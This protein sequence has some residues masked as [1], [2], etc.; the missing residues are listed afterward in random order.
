MFG[1]IFRYV[2]EK[3]LEQFKTSFGIVLK[4]FLAIICNNV[5]KSLKEFQ[6]TIMKKSSEKYLTE[7]IRLKIQNIRKL[8]IYFGLFH[9]LK[10]G[11]IYC[12]FLVDSGTEHKNFS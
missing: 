6:E 2:L 5:T 3:F 8:K 10:S 7:L 4:N 1:E 11:D 9:C 12:N